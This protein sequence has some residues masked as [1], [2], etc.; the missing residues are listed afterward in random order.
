MTLEE[1]R[2]IMADIFEC[3]PDM[4]TLDA[5]PESIEAWDSL[6]LLD[7]VLAIEAQAGIEI[8]TEN[9]GDMM[10]VSA[11]LDIANRA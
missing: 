6:R 4:I 1:L 10:S 11:I 2:P 7:L 9:L 3:S 8:P 5:T